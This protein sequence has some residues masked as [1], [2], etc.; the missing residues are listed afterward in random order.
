MN[1]MIGLIPFAL[2]GMLLFL[3]RFGLVLAWVE[4]LLVVLLAVI[5]YTPVISGTARSLIRTDPVPS[6]ADAVVVLS[7]GITVDGFLQGQGLDRLLTGLALVKRG[8]APILIV[9]REERDIGGHMVN[10]ARDQEGLIALANVVKFVATPLEAS[11]HDEAVAVRRIASQNGWKRILLVTSPFHT[12]RACAT[13]EHV[14]LVVSCFP[15][16]SRD[17]AVHSLR[18]SGDRIGAFSLWIYE[19]AATLQYKRRGWV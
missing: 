10:N 14:G 8:V 5:V 6:H 7:A 19:M 12:R 18:T 2:A 3:T 15:S 17:I 9:T 1:G 16:D 13:F 11:T 4:M